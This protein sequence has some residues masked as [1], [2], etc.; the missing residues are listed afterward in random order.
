MNNSTIPKTGYWSTLKEKHKLLIEED[1]EVNAA[2]EFLLGMFEYDGLPM[3]VDIDHLELY[4][5]SNGLASIRKDKSGDYV[6]MLADCADAPDVYGEGKKIISRTLNGEV[7]IDDRDGEEVA[8]CWNNHTHTPCVDAYRLGSYVSEIDTSLDLLVWWSRASKLFV[9]SDNKQKQMLQDAFSSV[10]KGT[11]MSI[12][13]ENIL[14]EIESGR[15]AVEAVDITD[16]SYADKLDKLAYIREKRFDWFKDR[17]GMCA[18]DTAKKAQVS[19]DEANGGTGASMIY[20]LNMLAERQR[21]IDMCNRKFGWSAEVHFAGA[22]LGEMERYETTIVENGDIDIDGY[23]AIEEGVE[24]TD[25][26]VNEAG[27][28]ADVEPGNEAAGS[29]AGSRESEDRE[30]DNKRKETE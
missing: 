5:L 7:F 26:A 30:D 24:A 2:F 9:A 3:S 14:R 12:V 4:I 13:S 16:A 8:Y 28:E 25:E 10:K 18:R 11:P 22:W 21:F 29:N 15:M 23:D 27:H 6:A 17:Y 20:P 19:I 1:Q